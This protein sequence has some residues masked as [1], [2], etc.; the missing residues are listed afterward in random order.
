MKTDVLQFV[1]AGL[2]FFLQRYVKLQSWPLNTA[3]RGG[4]TYSNGWKLCVGTMKGNFFSADLVIR[5]A[6]SGPGDGD[7]INFFIKVIYK[8]HLHLTRSCMNY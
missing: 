4:G 2:S 7:N 6:S 3:L 8:T 1:C 5:G